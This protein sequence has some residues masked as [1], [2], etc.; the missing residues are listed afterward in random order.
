[1]QNHTSIETYD[2]LKVLIPVVDDKMNNTIV[3]K[4]IGKEIR[5]VDLSM[6]KFKA[7]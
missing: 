6:N 7:P 2:N 5:L 3:K 4:V 1:M